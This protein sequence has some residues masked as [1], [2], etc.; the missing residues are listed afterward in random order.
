MLQ[1]QTNDPPVVDRNLLTGTR[2]QNGVFT[3]VLNTLLI[4][5]GVVAL[6]VLLYWLF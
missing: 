2:V 1:L 3:G 4:E 6:V 5:A